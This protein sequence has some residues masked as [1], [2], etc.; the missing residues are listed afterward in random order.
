MNTKTSYINGKYG[1]IIINSGPNGIIVT[2]ERNNIICREIIL[3][4]EDMEKLAKALFAKKKEMFPPVPPPSTPAVSGTQPPKSNAPTAGTGSSYMEQQ[5]A[6]HSNAYSQWT[7]EE[8]ERL[9]M[10]HACGLS[11]SEIAN[12]LGRNEGAIASRKNKL[13]LS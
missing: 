6:L 1:K 11:V 8:D 13:G 10:L 7:R 4:P 2:Q 9:R 12:I 5:K 3:A